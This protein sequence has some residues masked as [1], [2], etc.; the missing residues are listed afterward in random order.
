MAAPS[1][2][3][4]P[5]HVG[6][7]AEGVRRGAPRASRRRAS[8]ARCSA[9]RAARA[10]YARAAEARQE[11]LL[12]QAAAA[13]RG[14]ARGALGATGRERPW[15]FAVRSSATCEDGALVSMAG[16]AE[17]VLGVRGPAALVDAVRRVWASI[18][19]GRALGYLADARRARRRHGRRAP[20][21]GARQRRGRDVHARPRTAGASRAHRQRRLRPRLTGRRRRHDARHA[22][23]RRGRAGRSRARSPASCAPPSSATRA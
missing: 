17:T 9:P 13:P 11:I 2:V 6:A 10:V 20:A 3:P 19:S 8:R 22:A 21:D 7:A 12:G 16:L 1:R 4:R 15:G 18:A 23:H 5:R 14:G